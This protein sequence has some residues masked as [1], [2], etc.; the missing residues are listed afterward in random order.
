[1]GKRPDKG[2]FHLTAREIDI[3]HLLW[4]AGKPVKASELANNLCISTVHTSLKGLMEQGYVE[5]A[6]FI[7][8]GPSY[9]RT[10]RPTI[11]R[12]EFELDNLAQCLS[13]RNLYGITTADFLELMLQGLDRQTIL[14]DLDE[15]E[16]LIHAKREKILNQTETLLPNEI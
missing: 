11:A 2:K 16:L 3:L 5:V 8:N 1:M 12:R 9:A 6:D 14:K 10:F 15:L 4:E 7:Q 13:R